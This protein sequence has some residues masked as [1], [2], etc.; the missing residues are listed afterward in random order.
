[1]VPAPPTA[2]LVFVEPDFPFCLLEAGFDGPATR[3][4]L[5]E[6]EQR[7][8]WW[9]VGQGELELAA[10]GIAADAGKTEVLKM[11]KAAKLRQP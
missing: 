6:Q 5:A 8:A 1:M 9:S 4:D 11:L 10:I 7:H 3:R 2:D